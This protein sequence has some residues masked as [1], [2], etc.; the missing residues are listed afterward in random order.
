MSERHN[1]LKTVSTVMLLTLIGKVLGL[2][3]DMLMGHYFGTGMEASAFTVA[4]QIPRNFFDAIFASAI[5]AS[6]IPV[7][8]DC[9]EKKG[10][11]EAFR[12]SNSFITLMGLFTILLSAAGIVLAGPFAALQAGGEAGFDAATLALCTR[13]LRILFPTIVFTGLA[14]SMVGVLQS[15]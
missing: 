15:L 6:F 8:N 4:S 12:L 10:K 5:S 11:D 7:F 3:R 9:L 14:F 1:H 2:V 13:L